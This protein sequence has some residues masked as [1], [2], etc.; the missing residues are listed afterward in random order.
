MMVVRYDEEH[1]VMHLFFPPTE[2]AYDEEVE[3][4]IFLAISELS[5]RVVEAAV[6]DFSR[7]EPAELQR[8]LPP[9]VDVD[10]LF[11]QVRAC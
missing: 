11:A 10:S 2:L 6:L 8:V 3:P 1:D 4:G 7:R 5:G 9:N